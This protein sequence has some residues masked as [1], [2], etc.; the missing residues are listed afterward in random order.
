MT[1]YSVPAAG[2]AVEVFD[3]DSVK[4][5]LSSEARLRPPRMGHPRHRDGDSGACGVLI[6]DLHR[7]GAS[8]LTHDLDETQRVIGCPLGFG[9]EL[10]FITRPPDGPPFMP[11]TRAVTKSEETVCPDG[12]VTGFSQSPSE[13]LRNSWSVVSSASAR[14]SSSS[15]S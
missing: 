7:L 9:A 11:Y 5:A 1:L 2:A 6:A 12:R 3:D 15:A 14:P 4:S 13:R 10:G 8:L